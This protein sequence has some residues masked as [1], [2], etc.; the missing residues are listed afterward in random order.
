MQEK[1]KLFRETVMQY[2]Y[3]RD[4]R[5]WISTRNHSSQ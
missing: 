1:L 2:Q 5:N 4:G 3:A